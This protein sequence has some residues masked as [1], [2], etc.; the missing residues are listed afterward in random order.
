MNFIKRIYRRHRALGEINLSLLLFIEILAVFVVGPLTTSHI[1]RPWAFDSCLLIMALLSIN[2]IAQG[3]VARL[4]ILAGVIGMIISTAHFEDQL[5]RS[6]MIGRMISFGVFT[7]TVT[8][9]VIRSVYD[10]GP[11][12]WHRI[13]GA[14][15]IYLNAALLF[16]I[17]A[18]LLVIFI[19][20][21]YANIAD[22]GR[23]HFSEM[24]Y[25]SITT[26]TT[27]GYGDITPA[28]PLARSLAN[29]EE[30][31]GQLYPATLL[32]TL[33]GRHVSDRGEG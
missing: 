7:A 30:I 33:I 5:T 14:M 29:F 8:F 19:P 17:L 1:T 9:V 3:R 11:I 2:G 20:Q 31:V 4:M 23:N 16:A 22:D 12:T 24:I 32:A 25:F 10:D 21:A 28:H 15:I 6:Q 27:T 26:L 13:R 18:N